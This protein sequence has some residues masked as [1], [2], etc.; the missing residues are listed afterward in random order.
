MKALHLHTSL[1]NLSRRLRHFGVRHTLYNLIYVVLY[2]AFIASCSTT[3]HL[4][5]GEVLYTGVSHIEQH[6]VDT[7]D[8]K[9][10]SVVATALEVAPNSAFLGSAYRQ[11]FMPFGLWIYNGLYTEKEH[12]LRHWIWSHFKSDPTLVSQVNPALRAKAAEAALKD[13]G[14]F[15][16]SVGFDTVYESDD[17]RKAKIAYDVTFQH[18]ARL[19]SVTYMQGRD[20]RV[21]S[22]VRHTL[23]QG[24]LHPGDRFSAA[25]L[26]AEKQRIA[27][28]LQDSGYFFFQPDHV[29]FLGDS[30]S[31]DNTVNLRVLV[32]AGADAKALAPCTID[33]VHYKLDMGAGLK[34]Q[35]YDTLRYVTVGYSGPQQIHTK[36]LRRSL[37]FRRHALYN[38]DRITLAR[39]LLSRLNTFRYTTTEFQVLHAAGDTIGRSQLAI[40]NPDKETFGSEIASLGSELDALQAP[41]L[42][43]TTSLRLNINATFD[44]PWQGTTEVGC[45]Y[46]DNQQAGP[47][48]TFTA[49]RRNLWGGGEKLTFTLDGSY[50]WNT[51]KGSSS[52]DGLVNSYEFGAKVA[53]SVPRLQLPHLFQ[54]NRERPVSSNYSVSFDWM[55]RAGLFEMIKASGAIEYSFSFNKRN[56]LTFTPLKLSYVSIPKWS[57]KFEKIVDERSSLRHAFEDQFIPQ[58]QVAWTY[59]N[60]SDGSSRP[61]SQY[62]NVTLAEA[63]GLTDL[64]MGT[65]G[66][67]RE[68]GERQLFY[69]PFS[70]FVKG[71]F[72]VRN[73][74]RITSRL[75][76]ASRLLGGIA[77]AYG[78]SEE[79]PYSETFFIGGPNSLRGFSVRGVGPGSTMYYDAL[80]SQYDYLER[81]GDIKLEGN[82]ELRFPIAGS[83]YGALF[84]DAGNIW[85]HKSVDIYSDWEFDYETMYREICEL[86]GVDEIEGCS[87]EKLKDLME[88]I[89]AVYNDGRTMQ[90]NF[91]KQ[92]ALNTG[93]GFRLDL[94]ML[95]L[96]FDIGVPLHN[97]NSVNRDYFNC[98]SRFFKNLGYNLAV[99]YPF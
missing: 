44:Y 39:T 66:S 87:P 46:K 92:L 98:T 52:G 74:W 15:D 45:V 83:L 11:S 94:G 24:K 27:A 93:L 12:G 34:S 89:V 29:R 47:G 3:S 14:Y 88:A 21:D 90:G 17:H 68:Q 35:N 97:P 77:Y 72:E 26:E 50:E 23:V 59:D 53:L 30:T 16:A 31:H 22:I 79:L 10:K 7:L 13:E 63:G 4:P 70:Q 5:D 62:I 78:N 55:R 25:N 69:Q 20:A 6:K 41:L 48:V 38:P 43:D 18:H 76:L 36:T 99:G 19:G 58:M 86:E 85:Q 2:A 60:A 56:T 28:A 84:L 75:N 65:F 82:L 49:M 61:S 1:E 81:Y 54:P 51:G 33:S 67:H 9:V 37:G 80:S 8:E 40:L 73:L 42:F 57:D 32:G 91:F 71:T 96:R 64:A 95:V